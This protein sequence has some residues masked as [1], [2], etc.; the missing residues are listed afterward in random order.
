MGNAFY[1]DIR[2]TDGAGMQKYTQGVNSLLPE[3]VN[4]SVRVHEERRRLLAG[5]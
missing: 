1:F 2:K 5:R 3:I 4:R